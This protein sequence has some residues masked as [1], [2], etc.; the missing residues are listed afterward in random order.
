L[1]IFL[2]PMLEICA[3]FFA[4]GGWPRGMQL[5]V[6]NEE[7]GDTSS[8]HEL[9]TS[10]GPDYGG[11]PNMTD[12]GLTY[13]SLSG[14]SCKFLELLDDSIANKVWFHYYFHLKIKTNLGWV[15]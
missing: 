15:L 5:G 13:C 4:V 1:F 10:L 7:L 2:F 14:L 12:D 6:V 8:C 11:R 9:I 3:F